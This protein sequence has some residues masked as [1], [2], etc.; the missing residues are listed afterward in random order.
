MKGYRW[1]EYQSF[2]QLIILR[3]LVLWFSLVPVIAGFVKQLPDPLPINLMGR[4]YEIGLTL[5]FHWQLLWVSSLLFVFA[6]G[7]FKI[8]CPKFIQKYNNFS[9]YHS[10]GNHP[11]W[12]VW[13]A[14]N[15]LKLINEEQKEKFLERLKTKN[16]VKE[17][18]KKNSDIDSSQKYNKDLCDEPSVEKSQTMIWFKINGKI[19][20]FGMPI[21][22]AEN[23]DVDKDIFYEIFGRYSESYSRI[24]ACIKVLLIVSLLLFLCVLVEHIFHGAYF[25]FYN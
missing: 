6:L 1:E 14:H 18:V 16:Y 3:Y 22:D 7:L 10:Y 21:I 9:E 17:H 20:E 8:F 23:S 25:L 4:N 24:R 11:R 15:L 13:E 19:Y 12:L 2:F 5:P